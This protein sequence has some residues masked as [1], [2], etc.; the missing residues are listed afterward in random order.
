MA[1]EK[2]EDGEGE[3]WRVPVDDLLRHWDPFAAWC[4]T[5]VSALEVHEALDEG[6]LSPEPYDTLPLGSFMGDDD[7]ARHYH[8][9]RIAWLVVHPDDTPI[10]IDVGAPSLGWHPRG[11]A[12]DFIDGNHR[13]CA[14]VIRGDATIR[15]GYGGECDRMAELF[16]GG[17]V[18]D[19]RLAA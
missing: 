9:C 5:P 1:G 10:E 16:P 11:G 4:G 6:W 12:F 17:W 15:V 13:L 2:V 8:R 19:A 14:A 3:V 7:R 18:D